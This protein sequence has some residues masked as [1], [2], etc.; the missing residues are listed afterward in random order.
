MKAFDYISTCDTEAQHHPYFILGW[1]YA[2]ISILPE[3]LPSLLISK[4][5]EE[6]LFCIVSVKGQ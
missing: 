6:F 5:F 2:A 4:N 1:L 3:L